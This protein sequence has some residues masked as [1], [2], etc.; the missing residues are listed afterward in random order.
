MKPLVAVGLPVYNGEEFLGA[1]IESILAQTLPDFEIIISDNA[2]SDR[3]EAICQEY[4]SR[5]SR[6]SYHRASK[7]HGIVWNYNEVFRLSSHE[8][9]M[10][11]SHD[12]ILAPTYLERCV[13]VLRKDPSVVLCFANWGEIDVT[14]QLLGC[15]KS[16]IVM[17]SAKAIE[18]FRCAIRL[19]HLCEPWCGVTRSETMRKTALYGN[20]ADY[21]RVMIAELGLHGR[22]VEIPETLFFRREHKD[23]S[24]YLHP[25]RFERTSWID[26]E[27]SNTI[28]FPYFRELRE[29]WVAVGRAAL[30]WRERVACQWALLMWVKTYWRR[31]KAD[32]R[33]AAL[34][35]LRRTVLRMKTMR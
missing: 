14:S 19:D 18:R 20:F 15:Y 32:L 21:D 30:S 3:T 6:V 11:F 25:S 10:W 16:R 9:F 2:S 28:V 27:L 26:P 13:E 5:D 7:N 29:F 1:A 22:F 31:M 17:D 33:T 35:A 23:R 4:V 24:I 34:E 8:F 12:D